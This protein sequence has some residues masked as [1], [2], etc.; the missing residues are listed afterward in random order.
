[1]VFLFHL[2][3]CLQLMCWAQFNALQPRR[4][5]L[6]RMFKWSTGVFSL[7]SVGFESSP[8]LMINPNAALSYRNVNENRICPTLYVHL[9]LSYP[10][11]RAHETQEEILA[12]RQRRSFYRYRLC[13]NA[14]SSLILNIV[15]GPLP[16]K[17]STGNSSPLPNCSWMWYFSCCYLR[18]LY[19]EEETS[20][21]ADGR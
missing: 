18:W 14:R 21:A 6:A 1:M 20:M 2:C 10:S 11:V 5:L 3:I 8:N 9:Y 12:L 19:K 17:K 15:T 16:I 4:S 13:K 7:T